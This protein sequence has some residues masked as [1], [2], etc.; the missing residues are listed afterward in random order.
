MKQQYE[1]GKWIMAH[2]GP[3]GERFLPPEYYHKDY[4]V[5]TTDVDRTLQSALSNSAGIYIPP[6][7]K[8]I[9]PD[10]RWTPV[11]VFAQFCP[12][13]PE[14]LDK[15]RKERYEEFKQQL[16]ELFQYTEQRSGSK[17]VTN[18]FNIALLYDT[19]HIEIPPT[20]PARA[21]IPVSQVPRS[22][23]LLESQKPYWK[24]DMRLLAF[25]SEAD[26]LKR[27][28]E[29]KVSC[30]ADRGA[31]LRL[32]P[33]LKTILGLM[34]NN[35]LGLNEVKLYSFAAHD[36]NLCSIMKGLN[37]P[38]SSPPQYTSA[39]IFELYKGEKRYFVKVLYRPGPGEEPIGLVIPGC[40]G[41]Q[42]CTLETFIDLIRKLIPK[43]LEKECEPA[44]AE[45]IELSKDKPAFRKKHKYPFLLKGM[46]NAL[47]QRE[48]PEE[49]PALVPGN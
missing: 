37:L 39:I 2:Y 25:T 30:L 10:T 26:H 36:T 14:M 41:S 32:R 48:L 19:I 47:D 5:F 38:L 9:A 43:D 42:L 6:I 27:C 15:L 33:T 31:V 34:V 18:P 4:K 28:V 46:D 3:N 1:F 13:V 22:P 21:A 17:I 12:V 16:P 20:P 35:T 40:G 7:S 23:C 45:Y 44:T 8:G 11:P 49:L 29:E 24:V